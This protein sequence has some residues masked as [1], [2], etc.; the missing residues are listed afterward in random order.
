MSRRKRK[1]LG[2][3]SQAA[4]GVGLRDGVSAIGDAGTDSGKDYFLNALAAAFRR[5][6]LSA[7]AEA[8]A[9]E[10]VGEASSTAVASDEADEA[11]KVTCVVELAEVL[12][13]PT[14]D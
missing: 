3:Q 1:P 11:A 6:C 9:E 13:P 8:G 5:A 4:G 10:A 7:L 12:N 14:S 2:V